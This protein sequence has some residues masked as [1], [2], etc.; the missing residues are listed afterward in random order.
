MHALIVDN[1][2]KVKLYVLQNRDLV[3]LEALVFPS[4]SIQILARMLE[5]NIPVTYTK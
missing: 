2:Y 3:E 1:E 4:G 5:R